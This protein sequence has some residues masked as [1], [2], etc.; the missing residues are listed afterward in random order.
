MTIAIVGSREGLNW[1]WVKQRI[2]MCGPIWETT[3]IEE[4][5]VGAFKRGWT[6]DTDGHCT[7]ARCAWQQRRQQAR[8]A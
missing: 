2:G 4:A 6:L 8:A 7:C 3:A 1:A 5:Y